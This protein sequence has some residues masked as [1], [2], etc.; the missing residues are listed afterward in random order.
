MSNA[1]N[2]HRRRFLGIAAIT[3]AA[4]QLD[5]FGSANA[6]STKVKPKETTMT[7]SVTVPDTNTIRSFRINIPQAAL[8]DLRRRIAATRWPE[9][10]TVADQSQ[11]V[12]LATIQ[13]LAHYWATNYEGARVRRN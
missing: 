1:I 6:Q 13:K 2:H 5:R 11:G 10:E 12:Q 3:F 8:D 7:Q 4:T 9:K